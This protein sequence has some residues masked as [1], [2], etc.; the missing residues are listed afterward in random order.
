MAI[1]PNPERAAALRQ[2]K[3]LKAMTN[4][5]GLRDYMVSVAEKGVSDADAFGHVD[6]LLGWMAMSQMEIIGALTAMDQAYGELKR[7]IDG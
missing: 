6:T 3:I 7:K 5:Q 4:S 2:V 1:E